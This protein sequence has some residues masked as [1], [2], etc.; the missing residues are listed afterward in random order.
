MKE[1]I[2]KFNLVQNSN[3]ENKSLF[4]YYLNILTCE[5]D[6]K[7]DKIKN[8]NN[9]LLRKFKYIKNDSIEDSLINIIEATQF[10]KNGTDFNKIVDINFMSRLVD[11]FVSSIN[12][13]NL[14]IYTR[15]VIKNV[16][17]GYK[18]L[19]I[20]VEILNE[21]SEIVL[22]NNNVF[23]VENT[24]DLNQENINNTL[25]DNN[26]IISSIAEE[27]I[28][29]N[30][31][32]DEESIVS[33]F[34]EFTERINNLNIQEPVDNFQQPARQEYNTNVIEFT[35][36]NIN[37][38]N[39]H[40]FVNTIINSISSELNVTNLNTFSRNMFM[41]EIDRKRSLIRYYMEG[42]NRVNEN[43]YKP[44]KIFYE[45]VKE[46]VD[47]ISL[48]VIK[49][50]YEN[51]KYCN[52]LN[53]TIETLRKHAL[54]HTELVSSNL[55]VEKLKIID[56]DIDSYDKKMLK[57]EEV[58]KNKKEQHLKIINKKLQIFNRYS[59]EN[60]IICNIYDTLI[61]FIIIKRNEQIFEK[62][63]NKIKNKEEFDIK[64]DSNI[65]LYELLS[66]SE[67]DEYILFLLC[68]NDINSLVNLRE[69]TV[70]KDFDTK[71]YKIICDNL[72]TLKNIDISYFYCEMYKNNSVNIFYDYDNDSKNALISLY[73]KAIYLE[74]LNDKIQKHHYKTGEDVEYEHME[75]LINRTS[76]INITEK[77][78]EYSIDID[79]DL[80]ENKVIDVI[81]KD[82]EKDD[83]KKLKINI[84]ESKII[85]EY[86]NQ[87]IELNLAEYELFDCINETDSCTREDLKKMI[88]VTN[89]S[90]DEFFR[91][92]THMANKN[93][94]EEKDGIIKIIL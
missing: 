72:N 48:E 54:H 92:L 84:E 17:K 60:I 66:M 20:V 2:N 70:K 82:I 13:Q 21:I 47:F 6:K 40:S 25:E 45:N 44:I 64:H 28:S 59:A 24:E 37:L 58:L 34:R 35:T 57:S 55:I 26:S 51:I 67:I 7:L 56:I 74:Y 42:C 29:I 27:E 83:Y 87:E 81:N 23:N 11:F 30:S 65:L 14:K 39:H 75:Y 78:S 5:E 52:S 76:L 77:D 43:N 38:N 41:S 49:K 68:K 79:K 50:F 94:I 86:N 69:N 80:Y 90:Y 36:S 46:I 31:E 10:I 9:I 93:L 22:K 53:F 15:N 33:D 16:N 8:Y 91:N 19:K 71:F 3:T 61:G 18:N 88:K 12:E 1:L 32:D 63:K 73:F 62:S 4:S 85:F 89:I